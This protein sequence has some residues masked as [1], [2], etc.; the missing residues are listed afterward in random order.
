MTITHPRKAPIPF[1]FKK[2]KQTK[3]KIKKKKKRKEKKTEKK[4]MKKVTIVRLGP[5]RFHFLYQIIETS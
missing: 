5:F 4:K 2:N 1:F 3:N